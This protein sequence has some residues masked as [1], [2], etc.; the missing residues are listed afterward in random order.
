MGI[1]SLHI[2]GD[3]QLIINQVGGNFKTYKQELLHYHRRV[4]E[5]MKQIP[6]GKLERIS[7]SANV[8]TGSLAKLAKELIDLN[9]EEIQIT[10]WNKRVLSSCLD[11]AL[12][13]KCP[14]REEILIIDEDDWKE[15]FI[16][17]LKYEDL[18]EEKSWLCSWRRGWEVSPCQWCPLEKILWSTIVLMHLEWGV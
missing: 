10:I 9:Q 3:S 4:I 12:E 13:K 18:P 17:Y 1:Q 15:P 11:K 6:N 5:L 8:K 16:K 7:R 14:T 2:C